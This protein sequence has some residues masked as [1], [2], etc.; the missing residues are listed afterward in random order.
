[1]KSWSLQV[2]FMELRKLITYRADFW[3]NFFGQVFFSLTIA[4]FLWTSIFEYTKS[5]TMNGFSINDMVFYYLV[6]PL[7]FRIQQGQGIG[8]ISREIYEG[9]LSKYLLY[10]ISYFIFKMSAYLA[11]SFF[12]LL[13][14]LLI[15]LA[16]NIFFHD[17][18]VFNF[19]FVNLLLFL[20]AI[21]MATT[22]FFF[23]FTL[24]EFLAFWFD[25]VWSL[26]V[27]VRFGT[28]FLGGALLP[29]HFFPGWA[30]QLLS[31]TPFPYLID[32]PV[33]ALKGTVS[34]AM[35][36][37]KFIILLVWNLVFILISAAIWK[38]GNYQYTGVGI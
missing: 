7:I 2:F 26:G 16:Y 20:F 33:Q 29:L 11:H 17:P 22:C 21:S 34:T 8:F 25:N 28:S 10:P 31:Y 35:F 12:F 5:E 27:I 32:F 3:V 36:V 15:L 37:D 14:L 19:S 13:Q 4:Y 30:Q 23:M 1:M 24:S 6:A 18:E 38:R 9:G